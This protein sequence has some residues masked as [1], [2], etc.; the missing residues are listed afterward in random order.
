LRVGLGFRGG[1]VGYRSVLV[2]RRKKKER[3]KEKGKEIKREE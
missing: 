2:I 1:R 3:K